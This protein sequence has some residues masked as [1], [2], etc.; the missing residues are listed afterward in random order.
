MT[1][2]IMDVN[3]FT[4]IMYDCLNHAGDND[5]CVIMSTL[6]NVLVEA[7]KRAG[8][9]PTKYDKGHV[10]IDI[11]AGTSAT[12]TFLTVGAVIEQAADQYPDHIKVY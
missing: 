4:G 6:T 3:P 8:Y 5:A 1:K 2:V 7:A 10:R 11:P 12:E 9:V